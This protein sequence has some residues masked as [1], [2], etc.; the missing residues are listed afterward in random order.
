[1]SRFFICYRRD[2]SQYFA[3]LLSERI[4]GV[5]GQGSV[6]LDIDNIPVGVDFRNAIEYAVSNCDA[7]LVVIGNEWATARGISGLPRIQDPNDFVRLEVEYALRVGLP[8]IPV[9]VDGAA[10]P[11]ADQLPEALRQLAYRNAIVISQT[12]RSFE[13]LLRVLATVDPPA[14]ASKPDLA[15]GRSKFDGSG[16]RHA[17]ARGVAKVLG[18]DRP[19]LAAT[20]PAP[21]QAHPKLITRNDDLFISY[22]HDDAELMRRVKAYMER[23]SFSVWTDEKLE[24]GTPSWKR[25][26]QAAIENTDCFV[27]VLTP[28]AKKSE[29]VEMEMGYARAQERRVFPILAKGD[30][31]NAVPMDL[32]HTQWT[33]VRHEFESGMSRLVDAISLLRAGPVT[34][35]RVLANSYR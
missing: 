6:F 13:N 22:A 14:R 7:M 23:K 26:V 28:S 25:A 32:I 12:T 1:M 4:A 17:L 35:D 33:D 21:L 34:M 5:F 8:V 19:S 24:P 20:S 9:L 10:M 29:V 27:V 15:P 2:D 3:R 18:V 30:Q 16:W 31:R 11:H